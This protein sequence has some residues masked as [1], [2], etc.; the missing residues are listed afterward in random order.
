MSV[1]LKMYS[2]EGT[3][4]RITDVQQSFHTSSLLPTELQRNSSDSI[5][6]HLL[7]AAGKS[8]SFIGVG[9]RLSVE[10]KRKA[11]AKMQARV[12]IEIQV[13]CRPTCSCS[14]SCGASCPID[15]GS[16][17]RATTS[18][19]KDQPF[20]DLP[21]DRVQKYAGHRVPVLPLE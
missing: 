12:T 8:M 2:R 11:T 19:D 17:Q 10:V 20:H 15:L 9:S 18:P 13:I 3:L 6:M 14:W 1:T 21:V 5:I 7:Q 16:Q 4:T